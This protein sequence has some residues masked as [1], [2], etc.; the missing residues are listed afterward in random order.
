MN[1]QDKRK[2]SPV[3]L[4]PREIRVTAQSLWNVDLFSCIARL[5]RYPNLT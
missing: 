4:E 2:A 3:N 1:A 5:N